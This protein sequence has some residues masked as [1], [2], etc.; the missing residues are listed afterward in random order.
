MG[1]DGRGGSPRNQVTSQAG[2]S[3]EIYSYLRA[4]NDGPFLTD[5]MSLIYFKICDLQN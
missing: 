4:G 2:K 5:L 3:K 1:G